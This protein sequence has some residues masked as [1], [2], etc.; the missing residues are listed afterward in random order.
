MS[1]LLLILTKLNSKE[2]KTDAY[3]DIE[4]YKRKA[5]TNFRPL[6]ICRY[7]KQTNEISYPLKCIWELYREL[8]HIK[9]NNVE[10]CIELKRPP[11]PSRPYVQ[12]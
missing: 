4:K 11:P 9:Q 8:I 10:A 2:L 7:F 1:I 12:I 5:R 3:H 6:R